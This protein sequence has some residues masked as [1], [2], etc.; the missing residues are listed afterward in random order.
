[1]HPLV[2]LEQQRQQS[3]PIGDQGGTTTLWLAA[4]TI[5][6]CFGDT[7]ATR[8]FYAPRRTTPSS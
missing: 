4:V 7:K 6:G 5:Y 8:S 1:V 2:A 3:M